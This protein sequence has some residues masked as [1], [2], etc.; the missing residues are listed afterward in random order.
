M[1]IIIENPSD[2][3]VNINNILK[4]CIFKS[5]FQLSHPLYREKKIV[6]IRKLK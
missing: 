5:F 1:K 2:G 6:E 4:C 3:Y